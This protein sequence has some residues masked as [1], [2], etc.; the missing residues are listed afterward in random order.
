[1][2]DGDII[3]SN[4]PALYQYFIL[5]A[6]AAAHGVVMVWK[7]FSRDPLSPLVPTELFIPF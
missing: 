4:Q 1:M 7:I 2:N 6:P 5:E 3:S